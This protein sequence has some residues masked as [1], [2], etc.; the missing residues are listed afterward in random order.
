VHLAGGRTPKASEEGRNFLWPC[1]V[2]FQRWNLY[3]C[4]VVATWLHEYSPATSRVAFRLL[5]TPTLLWATH[6]YTPLSES[7]RPWATRRKNREPAG[8]RTRCDFESLGDVFT[9][10]PSLYHSI[11]GSGTP[12][13]LQFKVTGSCL[14]TVTSVGCSVIRGLR[15]GW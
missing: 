7:L 5:A 15:Y 12:S 1:R 13:A 14:G 2:K 11:V 4:F 6:Q 10:S 8:R 3:N 9:S